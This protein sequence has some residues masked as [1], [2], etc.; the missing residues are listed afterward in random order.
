MSICS[1]ENCGRK[2][3]C[4]GLCQTHD[5]RLRRGKTPLDAP[6]RHYIKGGAPKAM[7]STAGCTHAPRIEGLCGWCYRKANAATECA[8]VGC[9]RSPKVKGLCTAHYIRQRYGKPLDAP[10]RVRVVGR[11]HCTVPGCGRPHDAAGFCVK[12]YHYHRD[13]RSEMRPLVEVRDG[14]DPEWWKWARWAQAALD[15]RLRRH[16]MTGW[17]LW[18]AKTA[19]TLR[20][21]RRQGRPRS[22]PIILTWDDSCKRMARNVERRHLETRRGKW[23]KWARKRAASS[24]KREVQ[25]P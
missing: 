16:R 22:E 23:D 14:E 17:E 25:R 13:G 9:T 1:I 2:V 5:N 10:I 24:Y 21:P 7:C 19:R 3:V 6:V 18:A 20:K 12:H 4:R 15:N 11:T 8:V